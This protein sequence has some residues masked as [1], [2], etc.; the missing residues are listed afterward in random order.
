[1]ERVYGGFPAEMGREAHRPASGPVEAIAEDLVDAMRRYAREQPGAAMLWAL[2]IG[3]VL[4]WK[5]K[6]W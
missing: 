1:M 2:G 6:P 4:G 3:F 5:L